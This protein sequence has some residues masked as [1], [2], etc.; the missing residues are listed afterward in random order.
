MQVQP[1]EK[2]KRMQSAAAAVEAEKPDGAHW[3]E[4]QQAQL[5][6]VEAVYDQLT[7]TFQALAQLEAARAQRLRSAEQT[8]APFRTVTLIVN[9]AAKGLQDGTYTVDEIVAAVEGVGLAPHL[10]LT[11]PTVDAYQLAT[12]AVANGATL[13]VAAGG[14]GTIE[15]VAAALI[16]KNAVLGILP[17]GTMNNIA[18]VLGVPLVLDDA[19]FLLSL[20]A[21]RRLDVGHVVTTNHD[22]DSY[23]LETAGIGLSAIAAP[24][25]EAYEKGRW[26]ALLSQL[27]EL[28]SGTITQVRVYG[29]DE[30]IFQGQTH[31]ITI[32]NA[33]YFGNHMLIA[34]SAKLDDGLLDL[35][36]YANM[37]LVD[38]TAYFYAISG[39]GQRPE[40]RI[41]TAQARRIRIVA[42]T[43][44]AVNAD[45]DVLEKQESWE[46][47]IKPRALAVIAG[48]GP[49]LR[50]PAT[51]V[52][53]PSPAWIPHE[54]SRQD[55]QV[56]G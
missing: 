55:E 23:F 22:I 53:R 39:G 9:P 31:T 34:P 41:V 17:L 10:Q 8:V 25:G 18:H 45:L 43:P 50:F 24:M 56:I 49:G 5:Q 6:R 28:L 1:V 47:T 52:S 30:L 13:V 46:I 26:F 32:S 2:S 38:L 3:F 36:I 54:I 20:G 27:G 33:P 37:E 16:D 11:T 14:D 40:P 51:A 19:V 7:A 48:N 29:D 35:A 12:A 15:E 21:V 42:D 4:Q 44:L